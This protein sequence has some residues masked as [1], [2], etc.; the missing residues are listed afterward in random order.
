MARRALLVVVASALVVSGCNAGIVAVPTVQ[1]ILAADEDA[2]GSLGGVIRVNP[3][4]GAQTVVSSGVNF[5]EPTGIAIAANGDILVAD[6]SAFGGGGGGGP[7]APMIG[8]Q[9]VG[10]FRGGLLVAPRGSTMAA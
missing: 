2:V 8:G 7:G 10:S 6:P 3:A 5:V 9:T 4:T 1:T